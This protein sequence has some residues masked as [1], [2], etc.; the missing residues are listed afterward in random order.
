MSILSGLINAI[1]NPLYFLTKP[2][3]F[4]F[5][6]IIPS[7]LYLKLR[8][9]EKL[10]RY[11]DLRNPKLFTE[12]LQWLKL[13]DR[14]PEYTQIVDKYEVRKNIESLCGE[15]YL[16]PLLGFWDRVEDIDFSKLPDK[17]VLKCTHDS[18]S[19]VVCTDKSILDVEA[20][21]KKLKHR[22]KYNYYWHS[23]EY[24]YKNVRPRVICEKYMADES[25][26]ELKDYK[27]LC[28]N[29]EP[30]Y[31]QL[32]YDR[33][34]DHK[35]HVYDNEW[36]YVPFY[37]DKYYP[38]LSRSFEE[39]A[40]YDEML[41]LARALSDGFFFLRVDFYIVND[42]VFIGEL[43]LYPGSGAWLIEPIEYDNELGKLLDISSVCRDT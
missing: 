2:R 16:I 6:N 20:A 32:D 12:K 4:R 37:I 8:Y 41:S 26:T 24:P 21:K 18:G 43:T 15:Q 25:G 40:C 42:R 22:L 33:F 39:P 35:I 36:N 14:R 29:G 30:K 27:F 5:V 13:H 1:T 28:F 7:N 3:T 38:D 10:G 19:V 34:T 23:R 11:P 9:K 31:I 17:F